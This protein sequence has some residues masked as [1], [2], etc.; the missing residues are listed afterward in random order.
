MILCVGEDAWHSWDPGAKFLVCVMSNC[1]RL[2]N[3]EFS[4]AILNEI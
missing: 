4:M 3:T 1:K 2:E